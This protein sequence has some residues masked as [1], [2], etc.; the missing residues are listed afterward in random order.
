MAQK[1][2]E[3]KRKILLIVPANLRK[4]WMTELSEKF[5]LQTKI[6]EQKSF[7]AI[8]KAGNLNP[9]SQENDIIITSYQFARSKAPYIK[10]IEWD[11][12]VIDEAH[13]LRNVYK[14]GN[15]IAKEIKAAL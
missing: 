1:W 4:Q 11:L 6:L 15:K 14:N 13:R 9:F 12:V 2:A 8:I 5:F 10:N 3:K 7:N